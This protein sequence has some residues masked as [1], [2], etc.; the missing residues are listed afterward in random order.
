[1]VL[2]IL[3]SVTCSVAA[4]A[5]LSIDLANDTDCDLV[6]N[7]EE[8]NPSNPNCLATVQ[9]HTVTVSAWSSATVTAA[10]GNEFSAS[11]IYLAQNACTE[12][13]LS[14]PALSCVDC[15]NS[16]FPTYVQE[17]VN[18]VGSDCYG[19]EFT[20]MWKNYCS[21]SEIVVTQ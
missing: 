19:Y 8:I 9:T 11:W 10:V 20:Y 1:M 3:L 7:V 14:Y 13:T 18:C 12:V 2:S 6:F 16:Y 17:V 15:Q 21:S 4:F 5:Q